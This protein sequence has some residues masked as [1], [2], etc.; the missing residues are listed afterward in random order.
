VGTVAL[1]PPTLISPDDVEQEL[2]RLFGATGNPNLVVRVQGAGGSEERSLAFEELKRSLAMY[3]AVGPNAQ[4]VIKPPDV[5]TIA[6]ALSVL[7]EK[8]LRHR[9]FERIL[10]TFGRDLVDPL[11]RILDRGNGGPLLIRMTDLRAKMLEGVS[12][13]NLSHETQEV[14]LADLSRLLGDEYLAMLAEHEENAQRP[15]VKKLAQEV[16]HLVGTTFQRAFLHWPAHAE[17]I[18]QRVHRRF[19]ATMAL[20]EQPV[21]I[22][23]HIVGAIAE[24]LSVETSAELSGALS[25]LFSQSAYAGLIESSAIHLDRKTYD[26][27]AQACWEIVADYG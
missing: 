18:A 3:Q 5:S 7:T 26:D 1:D 4:L 20:G 25:Q 24:F 12:D 17:R 13:L 21:A 6:R 2:L 8:N 27:F 10:S 14:L 19:S 9:L 11:A 23:T 15:R 22:R 16:L